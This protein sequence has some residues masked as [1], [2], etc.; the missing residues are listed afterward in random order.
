[1]EVRALFLLALEKGLV[2]EVEKANLEIQALY[3]GDFIKT[4]L[5]THLDY[6]SARN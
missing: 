5:P 6:P 1:L 4:V 2:L 3:P